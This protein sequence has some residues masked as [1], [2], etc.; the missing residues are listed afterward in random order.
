MPHTVCGQHTAPLH[1][2]RRF[3]SCAAV[4]TGIQ[5]SN[6]PVIC[7]CR[8]A[9]RVD[10]ELSPYLPPSK[11]L[12]VFGALAPQA[13]RFVMWLLPELKACILLM[14]YTLHTQHRRAHTQALC[15]ESDNLVTQTAPV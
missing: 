11:R 8:A 5:N 15:G 12:Y 6:I 1:L 10:E 3:T 4:E 7:G 9:A 14:P 13:A 2:T